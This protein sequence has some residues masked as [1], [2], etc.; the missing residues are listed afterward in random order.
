MV[1]IEIF[2]T[3]HQESS[4]ARSAIAPDRADIDAKRMSKDNLPDGDSI[5]LFP[6]MMIGYELRRKKWGE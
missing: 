4:L 3:L 1:D 2:K 5:F 6:P